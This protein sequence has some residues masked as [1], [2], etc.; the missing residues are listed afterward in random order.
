MMY[1]YSSS[2]A[3]FPSP[4]HSDK[5]PVT[6][7]AIPLPTYQNQL[8][9]HQRHQTASMP[10]GFENLLHHNPTTPS[11]PPPR[12][13]SSP[14]YHL[15][16]RQQPIAARA[17]G[18]GDRDRRPVDPPPIIQLLLTDF[19]PSSEGDRSI[20][21]DPRFTVGCLLYPVQESLPVN[22][23]TSTSTSSLRRTRP[24]SFNLQDSNAVGEPTANP[25]LSGKAFVS[26][27]YADEEPDPNTAPM[28]PSSY[29]NCTI[30]P[31]TLSRNHRGVQQPHQPLFAKPPASFFIFSDLSVRSAGLYRLQF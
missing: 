23:S 27:F 22:M 16:I 3:T 26:P 24:D 6:Y 20:L 29:D 10:S 9:V 31:R 21:Q 30:S 13:P 14:R 4:I 12:K 11:P 19:N 2:S 25:L 5:S 28:H 15:S 17:C 7:S 1:R 18:A 8:P